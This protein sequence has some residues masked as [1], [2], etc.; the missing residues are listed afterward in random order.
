MLYGL[1]ILTVLVPQLRGPITRLATQITIG[2]D[3]RLDQ[4]VGHRGTAM[5][6]N[7]A[8][9]N[10]DVDLCQQRVIRPVQWTAC[11][12]AA[13]DFQQAPVHAALRS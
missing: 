13:K 1:P 7:F 8:F 5:I 12:G 3:K 2:G 10:R 4:G 6:A 9:A 11:D